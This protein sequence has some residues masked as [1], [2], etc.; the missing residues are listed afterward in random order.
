MV[1]I[2]QIIYMTTFKNTFCKGYYVT[3]KWTWNKTAYFSLF[4]VYYTLF[5]VYSKFS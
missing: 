1:Y 4:K 2:K 5:K 3:I